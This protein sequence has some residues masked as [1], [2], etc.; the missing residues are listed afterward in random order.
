M[1]RDQLLQE[2]ANASEHLI[3]TVT[4]AAQC[5]VTSNGETWG[6][7]EVMA[8]LAGWEVMASV[9]I[10]HILAGMA[11][12]EEVS[13][14]RQEVMNDAVNATIITMAGDQ[15]LDTICGIFRQVYQRNL[16]LL[17]TV[18]EK[19]FQPGEYLYER[20]KSVIEHYQEHLQELGLSAS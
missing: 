7:R 12:L 2:F 9:R 8:H 19:H 6:L 14:E 17:R 1:A 10:P 3:A 20:T 16:A 11:P 4:E 13:P 18:D 15:S 5:G